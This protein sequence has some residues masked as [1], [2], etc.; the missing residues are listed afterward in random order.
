MTP[1][2]NECSLLYIDLGQ[3]ICIPF[4]IKYFDS[5]I[6]GFQETMV[7]TQFLGILPRTF[8]VSFVKTS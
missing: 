1:G 7:F 6:I 4:T 3:S 5:A 2:T 8:L